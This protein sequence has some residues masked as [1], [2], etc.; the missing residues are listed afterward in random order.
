M[1]LYKAFSVNFPNALLSPLS[2]QFEYKTERY[3]FIGRTQDQI[4]KEGLVDAC[5]SQDFQQRLQ[6]PQDIWDFR[7]QECNPGKKT[8]FFDW[9]VANKC[10][11][12]IENMLRPIREAVG[13]GPLLCQQ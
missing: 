4:H 1:E 5:D 7:E 3:F 11:E 2:S 10:E 12:I 13:L 6:C 9:F 8:I